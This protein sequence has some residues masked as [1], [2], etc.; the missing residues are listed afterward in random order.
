MVHGHTVKSIMTRYPIDAAEVMHVNRDSHAIHM[1]YYL[2]AMNEDLDRSSDRHTTW[3]GSER[4]NLDLNSIIYKIFTLELA[5]HQH[6]Y[7]Y[8]IGAP[9]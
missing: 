1:L 7:L 9:L 2:T 3:N 4:T 6:S 8:N 5:Y